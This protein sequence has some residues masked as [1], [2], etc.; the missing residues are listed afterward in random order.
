MPLEGHPFASITWIRFNGSLALPHKT[1]SLRP[2]IET[3]WLPVL[4]PKAR[5]ASY[6][7]QERQMPPGKVL[8]ELRQLCL[9]LLAELLEAILIETDD[10]IHDSARGIDQ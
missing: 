6:S 4:Q 10:L 9:E 5:T 1:L 7:R 2:R 3:G 8:L